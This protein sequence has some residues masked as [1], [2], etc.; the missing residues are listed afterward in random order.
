MVIKVKSLKTS[1]T[2]FIGSVVNKSHFP[3]EK[4][5]QVFVIMQFLEVFAV[6][7]FVRLKY[8]FVDA[9]LSNF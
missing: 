7:N 9:L 4:L 3:A 6:M 5:I 1:K 8:L 2:C